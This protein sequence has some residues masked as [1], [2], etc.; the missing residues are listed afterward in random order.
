MGR[1]GALHFILIPALMMTARHADDSIAAP[2]LEYDDVEQVRRLG[3]ERALVCP[4]CNEPVHLRAP[5][6]RVW[7][8]AHYPSG[9]PCFLRDDADYNPETP[10]HRW[11]KAALAQWLSGR[12]GSEGPLFGRAQVVVEGRIPET[13]QFADVLCTTAGGQR[14]AFEVQVSPLSQADW[15]KRAGSYASLGI[16]DVWLLCGPRWTQARSRL[17][18]LEAAILRERGR[19]FFL[20]VPGGLLRVGGITRKGRTP[21]QHQLERAMSGFRVTCLDG[22]ARAFYDAAGTPDQE[23]QR[24]LQRPVSARTPYLH[25]KA[26]SNA[27]DRYVGDSFS[28]RGVFA[29]SLLR[30]KVAERTA[31][32]GS[33]FVSEAHEDASERSSEWN[34]ASAAWAA[35]HTDAIERAQREALLRPEGRTS[36]TPSSLAGRSVR[37]GT[38]GAD[39]NIPSFHRSWIAKKEAER[40]RQERQEAQEARAREIV[41]RSLREMREEA[42]GRPSAK[43]T[44]DHALLKKTYTCTLCGEPT[45]SPIVVKEGGRVVKCRAC[46]GGPP[47]SDHTR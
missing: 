47:P 3:R 4:G 11:A 12:L 27:P 32:P 13:G 5:V 10:A 29:G 46:M 16:H 14:I 17:G 23:E 35:A 15:K 33:F 39:E 44:L 22:M 34:E 43:R 42:L 31:S 19:V 9:R 26:W 30:A 1:G 6:Q 37:R 28:S 18:Q 20:E 36:R 40:E 38:D 45:S 21:W 8:F 25:A 24:Q 2:F 7:H 41:A